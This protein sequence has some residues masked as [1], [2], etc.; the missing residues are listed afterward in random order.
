[1]AVGAAI[2]IC[3]IHVRTCAG[4][5]YGMHPISSN[6]SLSAG[7]L[8]NLGR[9]RLVISILQRGTP[10]PTWFAE[11]WRAA[12]TQCNPSEYGRGHS[13]FHATARNIPICRCWQVP[14]LWQFDTGKGI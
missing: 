13:Y 6:R 7:P 2:G 11:N 5:R 4:T 8:T 1:M 10:P 14:V 12:L 3:T 9:T